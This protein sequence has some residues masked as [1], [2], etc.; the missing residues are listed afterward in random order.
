MAVVDKTNLRITGN[1]KDFMVTPRKL[2]A[3]V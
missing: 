2:S 3:E 1:G